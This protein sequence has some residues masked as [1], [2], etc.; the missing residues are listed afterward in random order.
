MRILSCLLSFSLLVLWSSVCFANVERENSEL[1]KKIDYLDFL[2]V[3][4][5]KNVQGTYDV[6]ELMDKSEFYD[7]NGW[8]LNK[9]IE[10]D[11]VLFLGRDFM[12]YNGVGVNL[13]DNLNIAFKIEFK[14]G[15]P[16]GEAKIYNDNGVLFLEFVAKGG[17]LNGKVKRYDRNEGKVREEFGFVEGIWEGEF[18]VF[19]DEGLVYKGNAKNG[20]LDGELVK[21]YLSGKPMSISY[22]IAGKKEGK[23]EEFYENGNIKARGNYVDGKLEGEVIEFFD[24]GEVFSVGLYKNDKLNGEFKSFFSNGNIDK[25]AFFADDKLDGVVKAFYKNGNI[26]AENTYKHDV[27]DGVWKGYYEDG[28][29]A[30]EGEYKGG[31]KEGITRGWYMGGNKAF[32]INF[33]DDVLMR[34]GKFFDKDGKLR[35]DIASKEEWKDFEQIDDLLVDM[36]LKNFDE[37]RKEKK[38]LEYVNSIDSV[39]DD[40]KS[41][42]AE[43]WSVIGGG[44]VDRDI[45]IVM[46]VVLSKKGEVINVVFEDV[47]RYYEDAYFRS[48]ADSAQRAIMSVEKEDNPFIKFAKVYPD[49]YDEWK[50]IVFDFEPYGFSNQ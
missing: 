44:V 7:L 8:K 11:N 35:I 48:I 50:E 46:K 24:C 20:Y 19:D 40:V 18:R 4:T 45:K 37:E 25:I 43:K 5:V 1:R 34:G 22:W 47:K 23:E 17:L 13:Y 6:L 39:V 12:P 28:S 9:V 49:L 36:I 29:L 26:R 21:Y 10:G 15:V 3:K 14:N 16:D 30:M 38:Y 32:E 31:K 33:K 27:K 42:I 2:T 41:K